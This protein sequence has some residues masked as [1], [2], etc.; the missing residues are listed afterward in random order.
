MVL[1][2]NEYEATILKICI[3]IKKKFLKR[4]VILFRVGNHNFGKNYFENQKIQ[5]S[6]VDSNVLNF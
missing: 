4:L 6:K 2:T 1:K 5:V 3:K